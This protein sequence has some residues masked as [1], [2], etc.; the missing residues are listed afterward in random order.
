MRSVLQAFLAG[1]IIAAV[2]GYFTDLRHG[3]TTGFL[4]KIIIIPI[5]FVFVEMIQML[6]SK[7][8]K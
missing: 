8:K 3:N 1:L 6:I 7:K 4:I 2:W 5:G